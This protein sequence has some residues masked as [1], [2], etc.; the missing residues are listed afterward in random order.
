MNILHRLRETNSRLEKEQI[1]KTASLLEQKMFMFAYHPNK[2]YF[3]RFDDIDYDSI[4]EVREDTFFILDDIENRIHV[5]N[6]A[7]ELI[8]Q[9]SYYHGDLIKL[10]CNK[11]LD[12]G[13]TEVTLNKV[14]GKDFIPTFN[15]QLA[16][17][18][19]FS[20]IKF[21]IIG[22]VKYDGVRCLAFIS[23]HGV[24]LKTRNGKVFSYPML[25]SCLTSFYKGTDIVLD[26]E[27]VYGQGMLV[28]RTSVSGIVN[29]AIRGTPIAHDKNIIFNVFDELYFPEFASQV[30]RRPYAMRMN[31]LNELFIYVSS[32]ETA[33]TIFKYVNLTHSVTLNDLKEL[34]NYYTSLIA[35]GC[36]GVILKPH[37][38]LYTF[39]RSTDWIKVKE[40]KAADLLC[41]DIQEGKGK[42]E[43]GIGALI[44]VG[45]VEGK[46]IEVAV[47]SG[48]TDEDRIYDGNSYIGATV[49]VKYNSVIQDSKTGK[50]SLFLPRF[51]CVRED[52]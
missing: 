43:G 8:E 33:S 39:K 42:Y 20:K 50:Y 10:I 26:G 1:L 47:G 21:P 23:D 44:C 40:T 4:T 49:E 45:S 38:H 6:K 2:M 31:E 25:E 46:D 11:D 27:L 13:V 51:V 5:G 30:C 24:V 3:Q 14:F 7:R 36:E 15:V 35:I 37:N 28:D 48:L 19:P 18:V 17:E 34:N 32:L 41:I 9:H 12:C 52:K 29:S 22:Q 16:K